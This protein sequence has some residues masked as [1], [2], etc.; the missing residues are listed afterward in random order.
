MRLI[1]GDSDY[2]VQPEINES[3]NKPKE[4]EESSGFELMTGIVQIFG[5]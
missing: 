2:F 5:C 1:C 3:L 4:E